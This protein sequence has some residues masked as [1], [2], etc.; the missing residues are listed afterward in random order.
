MHSK[1]AA[2][3][4]FRAAGASFPRY[5]SS[6][7]LSSSVRPAST[8]TNPTTAFAP[9]QPCSYHRP[10]HN[11]TEIPLPHRSVRKTYKS[12]RAFASAAAPLS[13]NVGEV[14][15][16]P[17]ADI[18]EGIT[19]CEVMQ[20]F[21]QPGD[22]ISQFGKVCEVQSDKATVEITSRFDG[23][24]ESLGY[25][26]GEM[27]IVGKPLLMIKLTTAVS[28]AGAPAGK[29]ASSSSSPSSSSSSSNSSSPAASSSS[30]SKLL[31]VANERVLASPSV[32]RIA[33][34]RGIDLAYVAGTGDKNQ[35][36]KADLLGVGSA[37]TATPA[38]SFTSAL[39]AAA[40]APAPAKLAKPVAPIPLRAGSAVKD[41]EVPVSGL[42]RIMV[43][44]MTAASS[45]PAFGYSD[46]ICMD[47]LV[48]LRKKVVPMAEKYGVKLSYFSFILKATS[49]ALSQYPQLNAH[50]NAD[51]TVTTLKGSHNI[52]L[53]MDTPRG[54]LVPNIKNVQDL[55]LLQIGKELKRLQDLGAAGKLGKDDLSGGTFTLSN[56]G[57]IGGTYCRPILVVP[58][59]TIGALGKFHV[60]PRF[61][62]EGK[63]VPSTVMHIGW[64]ADHRVLDGATVARFSNA[65]KDFLENPHTMGLF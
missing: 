29:S 50:V 64:T 65:W 21:V 59:V 12:V 61:D 45:I 62:K 7:S 57:T 15:A 36:T 47:E 8:F 2:R 25:K 49:L 26:V 31:A 34:E 3:L 35:I 24:V 20:W 43:K 41:T 23:V 10:A 42:Q 55:S 46:E 14:I 52:G 63:V 5:L 9:V 18:G 39:P 44:S 22:T 33:R 6:F 28:S 4:A 13:G 40:A 30:S 17:L 32:R 11:K 16:F 37:V 51:C 60:V 27:A 56:I 54:L 53:A 1:S 19:E 48:K 58:E 38:A